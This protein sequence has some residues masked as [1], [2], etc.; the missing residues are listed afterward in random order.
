[1]DYAIH[2][3]QPSLEEIVVDVESCIK[4]FQYVEYTSDI[5]DVRREAGEP[6]AHISKPIGGFGE[7]KEAIALLKEKDCYFLKADKG[8]SVVVLDKSDYVA[9]VEKLLD[10]SPYKKLERTPLP[11]MKRETLECISVLVPDLK[12][13]CPRYTSPV[14][15]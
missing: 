9:R 8:N 6:K 5:S 14:G 12:F 13:I 2:Q 11:R 1:L 4:G 3:K 10:E 7:E 15:K